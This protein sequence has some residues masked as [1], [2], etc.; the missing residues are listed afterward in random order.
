MDDSKTLLQAIAVTCELTGTTLSEA[1]AR[2]LAMDLK[3]YPIAQVL[4]A[5]SRCRKEVKSR[6]TL[7]DIVSRLDDGRPGPEEAWAMIPRSEDASV[8]WTEEMAQAYGSAIPL[9]NEGDQVAARMAFVERYRAIVQKARD[10]G[11]PPKWTP[12]LGTDALGREAALMDAAEKGR[13]TAE[14]V[15]GL[16]PYRDQPNPRLLELL[17]KAAKKLVV[18]AA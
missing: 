14:H 5:L 11:A 10:T 17:D 13:L 15:S 18:K 12:S 9:L 3:A 2:M 6:L 8:V 4:G 7:A 16:L 1:A